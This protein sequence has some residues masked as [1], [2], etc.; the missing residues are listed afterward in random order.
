L[1]RLGEEF[2][3]GMAAKQLEQ[4]LD[5]FDPGETASVPYIAPPKVGRNEPRPCG[6]GKKYRKCCGA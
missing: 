1:T 6:S 3:A 5:S 4:E 2:Q